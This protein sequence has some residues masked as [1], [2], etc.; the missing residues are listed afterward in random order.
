MDF[1][2][3]L[4][5]DFLNR[6]REANR[7]ARAASSLL[8]AIR[9]LH[10]VI[11]I[12]GLPKEVSF[13][14]RCEGLARGE[15]GRKRPTKQSQVLTSDQVWALD[16]LVVESC[17]SVDSVIGGQMLFALY[18]CARWDDSLHLTNIELSQAGRISLVETSTSKHK[19]SH[20]AHD[21]SLLLPLICLGRG[22]Y[23]EPWANSWLASREHFGLG[24][25]GPSLPTYCERKSSFGALPMSAT[26]ATLWLRDLLCKSGSSVGSVANITS[27]GLKA[28][29]LSWISKLGGW[30]ERDQKLMG[31]HFDRESRS[32]LIYG[33][34]SYTPLAM[35]TRLLLDKI[36]DG[37]FSPDRSRARRVRELLGEAS[38][39]EDE[40][41]Q[42]ACAPSDS[43]PDPDLDGI[44][45]ST[46][47]APRAGV[48]S[49]VVPEASVS[50]PREHLWPGP[51]R[52]LL[53]CGRCDRAGG[54]SAGMQALQCSLFEGLIRERQSRLKGT[55]ASACFVQS[56]AIDFNPRVDIDINGSQQPHAEARTQH[57]IVS[58]FI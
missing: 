50:V 57:R 21:R 58:W 47:F 40:R 5:Y 15:L 39:S 46:D 10:G 16:K 54:R 12:K 44:D 37:T 19:T 17:P 26:E 18:S 56:S 11:K 20:V 28:T 1:R 52:S 13:S 25:T 49:V 30:T 9:F 34:D 22:L 27:H 31:H 33:R 51:E 29:L 41:E 35:Q 8:S 45:P 36:L 23:S 4:L 53:V 55:R 32:V 2:E 3:E 38:N 14:A 24:S 7:G 42:E 43:G 6:I 48:E